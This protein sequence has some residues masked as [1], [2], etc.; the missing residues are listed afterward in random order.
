MVDAL[1]WTTQADYMGFINQGK[2]GYTVTVPSPLSAC[3]FEIDS[4]HNC[5]PLWD[6]PTYV[7]H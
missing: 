2:M 1:L 6:A 3:A 4:F 5:Q 7:H